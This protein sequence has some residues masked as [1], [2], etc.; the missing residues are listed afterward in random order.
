MP[1]YKVSITS[2]AERDIDESVKYICRDNTA[3]ADKWLR[4][5]LDRIAFLEKFPARAPRIPEFSAVG[6]EYRHLVFRN[7]R[8]VFRIK[9]KAVIVMRVV[10]SAR[11]LELDEHRE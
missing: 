10:H 2:A 8:I 9:G 4:E 5:I 3:A 7:H 1:A 6:E 11:L